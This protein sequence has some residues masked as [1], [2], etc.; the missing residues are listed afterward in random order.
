M[1][2]WFLMLVEFLVVGLWVGFGMIWVG[3]LLA[4]EMLCGGIVDFCFGWF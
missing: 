1:G 4:I 2:D 3:R